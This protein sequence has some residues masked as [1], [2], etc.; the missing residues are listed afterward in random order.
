M[1]RVSPPAR[2]PGRAGRCD[3]GRSRCVHGRRR[4]GGGRRGG[5]RLGG[6]RGVCR[7]GRLVGLAPG[8]AAGERRG[9]F[10]GVA[11]GGAQVGDCAAG[12]RPRVGEEGEGALAVLG[13]FGFGLRGAFAGGEGAEQALG[14]VGG[15]DEIVE[16]ERGLAL[17]HRPRRDQQVAEADEV[18]RDLAVGRRALELGEATGVEQAAVGA[19]GLHRGPRVADRLVGQAGRPQPQDRLLAADQIVEQVKDQLTLAA[20]VGGVHHLGH[21]V[22]Q[23]QRLDRLELIVGLRI[24]GI[25][26]GRRQQ[27][28]GVEPPVLER[29]VVLLGRA[30]L[31]QVADA[32]ADRQIAAGDRVPTAAAQAERLGDRATHRGFFGDDQAHARAR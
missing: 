31:D 11:L 27:R 28:Q 16:G 8:G 9:D 10:F 14:D 2:G 7:G 13:G 18:R 20:G 12:L 19:V 32:P 29:R 15:V 22:A 21:V 6:G 26:K 4:C 30:G 5:L 25:L 17:D 1:A 23:E 3:R 24:G